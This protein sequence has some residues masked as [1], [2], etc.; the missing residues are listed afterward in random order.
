M[1]REPRHRPVFVIS[2]AVVIVG[3]GAGFGRGS[4][5]L[6]VL[7]F[8]NGVGCGGVCCGRGEFV[9]VLD[10]ARLCVLRVVHAQDRRSRVRAISLPIPTALCTEA[11]IPEH[12]TEKI[13]RVGL[14]ERMCARHG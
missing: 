3:G 7:N 6:W 4:A 9:N 8:L 12:G 13:I 11:F 5:F 10:F 2:A 14:A 1:S